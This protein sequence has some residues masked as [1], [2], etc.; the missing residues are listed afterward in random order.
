MK[1]LLP[2]L[3]L[4]TFFNDSPGQSLNKQLEVEY[5]R[6]H[7]LIDGRLKEWNLKKSVE[8]PS[9][10]STEPNVPSG[11][12]SLTWNDRYLF[13]CMVLPATGKHMVPCD[14][15]KI[16]IHSPKNQDEIQH[17]NDAP[18]IIDTKG[19]S[20]VHLGNRINLQR[21]SLLKLEFAIDWTTTGIKP[22]TGTEFQ[23]QVCF[24][25]AVS[26]TR[27]IE[28]KLTGKASLASRLTYD[29]PIEWPWLIMILF[30]L[31]SA[32]IV[33][34]GYLLWK[35]RHQSEM[36]ATDAGPLDSDFDVQILAGFKGLTQPTI[37]RARDFITSRIG[38]PVNPKEVASDQAISVRNM[39][40]I[41]RKEL[42][43]TPNTFIV[44]IKLEHASNLLRKG[45]LNI[46]EVA[47]AVGFN[48]PAYFSRVFKK[49]YHQ[50]PSG[51]IVHKS[52]QD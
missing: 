49:Y 10:D 34:L 37:A 25:E 15:V 42:N 16:F 18:F 3:F 39:Q 47:N 35:F 1:H 7:I 32:I 9:F 33:A 19:N 31:L 14:Q 50:T 29:F 12:F 5:A 38:L 26:Q 45:N 40:R 24:D 13:G 6:H 2:L 51:F 44:L 23:I 8:I 27:W 22:L 17:L 48:D 43:I 52:R 36:L 21:D 11:S 30:F 4:I 41:F 28:A 20:A 46:A